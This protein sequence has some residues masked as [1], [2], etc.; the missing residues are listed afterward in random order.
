MNI[1]MNTP[2]QFGIGLAI[3]G[4]TYICLGIVLFLD[5]A[6][7]TLGNILFVV[8]V[9]LTI[10]WH[11]AVPFFFTRVKARGSF[12]FFGGIF[13]CLYGYPLIGIPIEAWGFFTLFGGFL[14]TVLSLVGQIPFVGWI[15]GYSAP[16]GSS[17]TADQI[18]SSS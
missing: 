15:I 17:D 4:V 6:L 14:R 1:E 16:Q 5:A 8:G 9:L 7:L 12:F 13:V 11:R 10:G 18:T 3:F 2:R